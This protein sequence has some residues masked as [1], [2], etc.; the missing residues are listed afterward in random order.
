[1]ER[2]NYLLL[3]SGVSIWST[4][5]HHQRAQQTP[6]RCR[7]N[8]TGGK[9]GR[10]QGWLLGMSLWLDMYMVTAPGKR[11]TQL[12]V[13]STAIGP[14]PGGMRNHHSLF[15]LSFQMKCLGDSLC[16]RFHSVTFPP[17]NLL[18]CLEWQWRSLTDWL[19]GRETSSRNRPGCFNTKRTRGDPW[20]QGRIRFTAMAENLL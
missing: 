11:K 19:C 10:A 8:Q 18:K 2:C 16:S 3:S 5:C 17:R 4:Y 1:M 20:P 7:Q 15:C 12:N 13:W 6:Q 9:S 14:S